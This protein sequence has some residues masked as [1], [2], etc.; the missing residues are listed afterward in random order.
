MCLLK[1]LGMGQQQQQ[2]IIFSGVVYA[3][4]AAQLMKII[5]VSGAHRT[6]DTAETDLASPLSHD[7][8]NLRFQQV[9]AKLS[10]GLPRGKQGRHSLECKL[11]G[12]TLVACHA[13][14]RTS[15]RCDPARGTVRR[16]PGAARPGVAITPVSAD[17]TD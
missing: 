8:V 12:S 6:T 9:P 16:Q 7:H 10:V 3:I 2:G 4:A 1:F 11:R 5:H 17:H 15:P 14:N 13:V